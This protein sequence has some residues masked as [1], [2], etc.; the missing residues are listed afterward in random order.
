[1]K[2]HLLL[3][4]F[5]IILP[6]FVF[7]Q[8]ATLQESVKSKSIPESMMG[9]ILNIFKEDDTALYLAGSMIVIAL[10]LIIDYRQRISVPVIKDLKNINSLFSKTY[11]S[12]TFSE[13]IESIKENLQSPEFYNIKPVWFEF[14]ETL[15]TQK[16]AEGRVIWFNT[17]RPEEYFTPTSVTRNRGNFNSIESWGS[18]FVGA[19]LLFTFLGLVAALDQAS[20]A[21][22]A[23]KEDTARVLQALRLML[24]ISA[25]KFMTSVAG[26]FC[27]IMITAYARSSQNQI[28][29]SLNKFNDQLERCLT[30]MPIEQLQLRTIE[31]IEKMSVSVSEGVSQGVQNIAGNELRDF[32]T[33][34]GSIS[35]SLARSKTDIKGISKIYSEEMEKIKSSLDSALGSVSQELENWTLEMN[36]VLKSNLTDTNDVL[37]NF[38]ENLDNAVEMSE[39]AATNFN[40]EIVVTINDAAKSLGKNVTDLSKG[41]DKRVDSADDYMNRI[42]DASSKLIADTDKVTDA[43]QELVNKLSSGDNSFS[44]SMEQFEKKI[45]DLSNNFS[46]TVKSIERV[47]QSFERELSKLQNKDNDVRLQLQTAVSQFSS[48]V[49]DSVQNF[50]DLK[51]EINSTFDPL[52][53][54]VEELSE[55]IK[56]SSKGSRL[57]FWKK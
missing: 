49:S 19:G 56:K 39:K 2:F 37:L 43:L 57:F 27:S 12:E 3:N 13:N 6:N 21:I 38:V 42:N 22:S 44:K 41:I 4:F 35:E 14:N 28:L 55:N 53:Q 15:T 26:I 23:A 10:I 51:K 50:S 47:S 33:A 36:N 5:L 11:N 24:E 52:K 25:F 20:T 1:M 45:D 18:F 32:A 17:K 7:A 48:S 16:N 30:F 54:S 8:D 34:L 46:N 31:A 9:T 29:G 40:S